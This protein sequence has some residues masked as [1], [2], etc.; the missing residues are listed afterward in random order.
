MIVVSKGKGRAKEERSGFGLLGWLDWLVRCRMFSRLSNVCHRARGVR[1]RVS[2]ALSSWV[3]SALVSSA[4]VSSALV[5]SPLLRGS[6]ASEELLSASC[7]A[8][9]N[10][11]LSVKS[12]M[13][14]SWIWRG[15]M[16]S[17]V[18]CSSIC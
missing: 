3:S 9:S 7:D 11:K 14:S 13:A 17:T 5:E 10:A 2:S 1:D 4:L 15:T 12:M 8:V 16:W 6:N 18:T